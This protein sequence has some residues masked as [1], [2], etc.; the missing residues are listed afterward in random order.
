MDYILTMY[1]ICTNGKK[2]SMTI[3]SVKHDLSD[4]NVSTL[5]QY[6]IDS[7][8]FSTSNGSLVKISGATL[9]ARKV[10]KYLV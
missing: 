9:T 3:E 10:T 8:V 7:D 1:F 4:A 2:T 5:M 6:I